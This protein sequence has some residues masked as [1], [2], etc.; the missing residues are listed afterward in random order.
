MISTRL[1][2]LGCPTKRIAAEKKTQVSFVCGNVKAV[3]AQTIANAVG[4]IVHAT[5]TAIKR[6][7]RK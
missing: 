3:C 2:L 1:R 4:G 6:L 7:V 5:Q